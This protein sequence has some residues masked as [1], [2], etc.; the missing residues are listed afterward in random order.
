MESPLAEIKPNIKKAFLSNILFVSM[1]VA[2]LIG[3]L[4]YLN[5]IVGLDIFVTSFKEIGITLSPT[6]L[7]TWSILLI[8][9]F[10]GLTLFL[11]YI[12]LAN[13]T[14]TLYP[15]RMV[16]ARTFFIVQ[17][18]DEEIPYS[19]ISKISYESKAILDTS[20]VILDLTGMKR[21]QM[22]IDFIDQ[23]PEL[24][25]QLQQAISSFRANY[26]AKYAQDYRYQNIMD[27]M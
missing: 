2:F 27:Q 3:T 23:A 1:I 9:F 6:K 16:F 22:V 24:V 21:S 12:V 11:N 14:Y 17:L 25:N 20:K 8:L 26:Y 7:L 4:I 13:L 19:N 10:T 18:S 5:N 15:D